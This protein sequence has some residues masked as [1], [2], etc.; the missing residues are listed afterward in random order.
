MTANKVLTSVFHY[1][2]GILTKIED[3]WH[4]TLPEARLCRNLARNGTCTTS[5]CFSL[6][7]LQESL[8]CF[9]LIVVTFLQRINKNQ[10]NMNEDKQKSLSCVGSAEDFRSTESEY[11]LM[12][13]RINK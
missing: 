8:S 10:D 12:Q 5:M 3:T 7:L 2:H 11:I 13:L 1:H 6:N 9:V 4:T